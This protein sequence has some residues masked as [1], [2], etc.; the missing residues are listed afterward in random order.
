MSRAPRVAHVATV[1][2]THRFLLLGQLRAL[3]DEGF[4]VTAVSAPGP[5]VGDLEAEGI[6]HVAWR[7]ASRSWDP[8]ADARAFAELIGILRRGEFDLVH[9]HN[10]KPGILGRVG[11]RLAGVPCVANTVHGLYATPEDRLGRRAA[12]LSLEWIAARFSDLELYQSEE[13]LR[14]ARRLRIAR[15][16]RAIHLGNGIDLAA[17]DRAAVP[18]GRVAALR[19]ELGIPDDAPVV[20]TVGRLVAEKGAREFVRAARSVRARTGDVAFL[21]I[22]D[23]DPAKADSLSQEELAAAAGDVVVTGWRE[24]VRD[25]LALLDVFVL[26]SHREGLPRS[27]IEAAA[28]GLPLVVTDIRGCREVVRPGIE[29]VL[30]PPG[31]GDLLAE[32]IGSLLAD[33]ATRERM[34]SAAR[35]RAEDQFDERRVIATVVHASRRMLASRG[36]PTGGSGVPRIRAARRTD[37]HSMARIHREAL[38]EAFLSA[39]GERFLRRLYVAIAADPSGLALVA[40]NG[41]GVV[42]FAAGSTSVDRFYRRFLVRYGVGAAVAAFPAVLRPDVLRRMRETASHPANTASLPPAELLS[43]AVEPGHRSEGVGRLLA[44]GIVDGL[45]TRGADEVKVVVA[46]G[47]VGA[48]RFYERLGFRAAARI[49]VHGSVPSNVWVIRCPR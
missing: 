23:V 5:W 44:E 31:D 14:W 11:A 45:A 48:N 28:M 21:A 9:T 8:F 33:P 18:D 1:D 20:G 27:A 39:L 41:L 37:A 36:L 3:R 19:S 40:E 38:P 30:V 16:A 2:L 46:G 29:G 32:A 6:R 22:G 15:R 42:G 17:F 43:I 4:E 24:D 35:A 49:E 13:D 26:A 12:V 47:N 7:N 25:L 10:P 34:G